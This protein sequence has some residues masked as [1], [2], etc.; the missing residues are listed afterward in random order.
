MNTFIQTEQGQKQIKDIWIGVEEIIYP[1][2]YA[3]YWDI[4]DLHDDNITLLDNNIYGDAGM[5][6]STGTTNQISFYI[7]PQVKSIKFQPNLNVQPDYPDSIADASCTIVL[8]WI[9]T[10]YYEYNSTITAD[11]QKQGQLEFI[12]QDNSEHHFS[13]TLENGL[14]N[15]YNI[16]L[17]IYLSTE[18]EI[19]PKKITAVYQNINGTIQKIH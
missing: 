8:D 3:S 5:S 11:T 9:D 1:T 18:T 14:D 7:S 15:Y 6:V 10:L 17:Q 19:I 4:V 16:T 2:S 13:I 12:N